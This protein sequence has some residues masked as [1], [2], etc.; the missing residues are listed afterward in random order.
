MFTKEIHICQLTMYVYT[1]NVPYEKQQFTKEIYKRSLVL[2]T[3][4]SI[5][6]S[7][8]PHH[9]HTH[10]FSTHTHTIQL[11]PDCP[12]YQTCALKGPT[13]KWL[14]ILALVGGGFA[15]KI[16]WYVHCQFRGNWG[17][18]GRGKVGELI[19]FILKRR[20]PLTQKCQG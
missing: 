3:H 15:I 20:K 11:S 6:P 2:P 5:P 14:I 4:N 12:L 7:P 19:W 1:K 17:G 9:T 18:V 16:H 8:H 10:T 13:I